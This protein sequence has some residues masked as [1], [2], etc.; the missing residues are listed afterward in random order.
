MDGPSPDRI[1]DVQRALQS[2]LRVHA[3][4]ERR[5]KSVQLADNLASIHDNLTDA[6]LPTVDE[7]P[8]TRAF[9]SG[10]S[11]NLNRTR[12]VTEVVEDSL[13]LSVGHSK[14]ARIATTGAQLNSGVAMVI[15][16]HNLLMSAN[17][18]DRAH[19][20][21]DSIREIAA[22]RF[23]DFYRAL[24]V[25]VAEAILFSTPIN[26]RLAWK[27]TRVLNNRFLYALRHSG[28]SGK[29]DTLLKGLHRL[30]LSEIHYAIRGVLPTALR[31]PDEFVTYLS[32]VATQ[33]LALLQQFSELAFTELPG[34]AEAVVNEYRRFVESSYDIATAS[35]DV[36]AV[37]SDVAAQLTEGGDI[38]SISSV[39]PSA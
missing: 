16:S 19:A 23:H 1:S 4:A 31:T 11:R 6:Q 13:Q 36:G 28:L 26:Y 25:F 8:D 18:L 7:T 34:K 22:A 37:A 29:T 20:S 12:K 30:M 10:V 32:S 2:G 35:I 27:G 24:G 38:F 17:T 5:L 33:T 15:A 3:K 9:F 14:L 39:E 21:V